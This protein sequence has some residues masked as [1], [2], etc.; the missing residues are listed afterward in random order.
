MPLRL[1]II[2]MLIPLLA[3]FGCQDKDKAAVTEVE[4]LIL[5][6][7]KPGDPDAKIVEFFKQNKFPYSFD[8]FNHRYQ[9]GVPS[10]E[11]TDSKGVKSVI[12][13]YIYVNQDR[14]FQKAEVQMVYT[15]L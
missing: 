13:I 8:D 6:N 7:L 1:K 15:Y 14:S 3:I 12:A 5:Q 2:C 9:S 4:K 10:S 11:K